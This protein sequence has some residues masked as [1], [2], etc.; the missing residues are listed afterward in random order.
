MGKDSTDFELVFISVNF[1]LYPTK[2]DRNTLSHL[3]QVC[4]VENQEVG[5]GGEVKNYLKSL[6]VVGQKDLGVW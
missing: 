5:A 1:C 2:E 4:F 6:N 3:V